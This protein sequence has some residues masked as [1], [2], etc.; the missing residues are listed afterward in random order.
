MPVAIDE[1]T[2]VRAPRSEIDRRAIAL[3]GHLIMAGVWLERQFKVLR[4]SGRDW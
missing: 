4:S 2:T 3:A 1:S